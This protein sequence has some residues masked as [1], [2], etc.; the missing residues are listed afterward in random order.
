[1]SDVT[2]TVLVAVFMIVGLAGTVVPIVPGL[3]VIWAAALVYGL[4]VGFGAL[5]MAVMAL[6]TILLVVGFVLGFLLPKRMADG[7]DVS[8][9][10]QL[11]ALVGAII[12]FSTIPVVGVIVGALIGLLIAEYAS[13]GDWKRAWGATVAMAKGFGLS[14]LVDIGLATVMLALW[15]IWAFTV[16]T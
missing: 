9:R 12:G 5:G 8:R 4:V 14:A 1:M 11:V 15:S 6:L 3:V 10:S 16:V 2:M 13:Q 7:H